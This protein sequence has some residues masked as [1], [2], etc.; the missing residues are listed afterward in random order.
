[1][2]GNSSLTD[3]RF[4]VRYL[5]SAEHAPRENVTVV[6]RQGSAVQVDNAAY[7]VDLG[8]VAILPGLVNAHTHLEF[9]TLDEPL[10]RE[11]STSFA[12][13]VRAVLQWRAQQAAAVPAAHQ[14]AVARGLA[15]SHQHGTT[16]IGEIA[17]QP[18]W[19]QPY[20]ATGVT[21][22]RFLELIGL[23]DDRIADLLR[24]A[25]TYLSG[26]GAKPWP[27]WQVGLSPHAPYTV[28]WR[29]LNEVVQISQR[30]HA[31]LAMHLAET[32]D[33][34]QLLAAQSGP[35]VELL[36][37]RGLWDPSAIPRGVEPLAYLEVLSQAHRALVIHGNY[38]QSTDWEFL[39]KHRERLTVVYCPRTFAYFGHRQYPLAEMLHHGVH[40]AVGTDSR[41]SNPDL[42]LFAELKFMR[43]QHP[44]VDLAT[45]L[46]L[47]TKHGAEALGCEKTSREMTVVALPDADSSDP[48]ELLFDVGSQVT[49]I[50]SA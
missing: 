6:V 24:Q 27:G 13:W 16:V 21:G 34:I 8:N 20:Q 1:M 36:S 28:G 31:P 49:R 41:A 30:V 19:P 25:N 9:S 45:I 46:R 3:R 38:L 35:L 11:D 48:Y 14:S 37:E 50:E 43:Q 17:T 32:L 33:E 26:T 47:G 44:D 2:D 18:I 10:S 22:V 12:D 29:L 42:D 5:F 15:E 7:D 4:K 39:A 40:V 23:A